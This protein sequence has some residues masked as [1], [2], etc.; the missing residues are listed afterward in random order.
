MNSVQRYC[1]SALTGDMYD[2]VEWKTG[3]RNEGMMSAA[4]GYMTLVSNNVSSILSGLIIAAIKYQPLLNSH[5]VVIPQT[6]PKMLRAIW[7]VFTLAPAIGRSCK[8]LSLM[9][10]NVNGKVR[11]QMMEDLAVSRAGKLKERTA[12][13]GTEDGEKTE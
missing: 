4:M 6:D 3:I 1:N 12:S 11:E 5:G 8:G 13:G 2:Y 9:F 10:F 7:T